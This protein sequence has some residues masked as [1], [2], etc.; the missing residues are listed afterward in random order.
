[1]S[2]DEIAD[3]LLPLLSAGHETTATTL[4]WAVERLRRHPTALRALV[5]EADA[6]GSELRA[7]TILE[8]QRTRPVIDLVG[9]Q[10]KTDTLQLGRWR[11]PKGCAV[12]VSITLVHDDESVFP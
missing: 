12:L 1:M 8:V 3:Q 4:A 2:R 11:L 10:V 6:G 7:A 5:E 9:R